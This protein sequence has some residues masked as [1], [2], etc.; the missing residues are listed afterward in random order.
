MRATGKR[1]MQITSGIALFLFIILVISTI[2]TT[3]LTNS[4][5]P[6]YKTSLNN[7]SI[8]SDLLLLKYHKVAN[9]IITLSMYGL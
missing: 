7:Q 9:Q 8:N 4:L 3:T 1:I 2:K 6:S 5:V